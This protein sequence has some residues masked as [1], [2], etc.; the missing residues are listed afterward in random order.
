MPPARAASRVR[1]VFSQGDP[2]GIH[3]HGFG[4]PAAEELDHDFLWRVK[5]ELPKPGWIAV[6]DRSHYEDVVMPHVYGTY[7]KT[8]GVPATT[9]STISNVNSPPADAP[10]SRSSSW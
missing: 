7:P 6:F 9:R 4:K 3:Y 8:Y 5:R 1:H 2:M 10:S